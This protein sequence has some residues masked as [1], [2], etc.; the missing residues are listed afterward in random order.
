LYVVTRSDLPVGAQA[1]Q[2]GHALAGYSLNHTESF[3]QW[4]E[5]SNYLCYLAVS[6]EEEL[7]ALKTKAEGREIALFAFHEPDFDEALT[8][9]CLEPTLDSKKLTSC[10]P[11]ALRS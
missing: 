6:N 8:A 11:L 3:K 1:V 2:A 4:Y 9:I 5:C 10:L 7:R